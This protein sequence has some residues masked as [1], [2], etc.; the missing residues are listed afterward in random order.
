MAEGLRTFERIVPGF[1]A[2]FVTE[3]AVPFDVGSGAALRLAGGWL[4]REPTGIVVYG[5]SRGLLEHVLRQRAAGEPRLRVRSGLRARGLSTNAAGDR[6][7]GVRVTEGDA[8][9]EEPADLTVV[10]AGRRSELP[11]WL[12]AL[13]LPPAEETR[14]RSH[15]WYVSRWFEIPAG[16]DSG[17]SLMSIN[18]APGVPR[19]GA[20]LEAE[21]GRWGVVLVLPRS[22]PVPTTDRDFLGVCASLADDRLHR[23]LV[24]ARP[25]TPILRHPHAGSRWRHLERIAGWPDGLVALGDAVCLLDP[26]FG[27]GM[28]ACARG[29]EALADVQWHEPGAAARYQRTLAE[30]VRAPWRLAIGDRPTDAATIEHRRR[31]L[32]AAPHDPALARML[33]R[34]MHVLDPPEAIDEPAVV[35]AVRAA[36][37]PVERLGRPASRARAGPSPA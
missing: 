26:F 37:E 1:G 16:F 17:W 33:L 35:A 21:G 5:G 9:V 6:V 20:V 7:T 36:V 22:E 25:L 15:H 19:G 34:R 32:R 10:A 11:G 31:L 4:P 23:A 24:G 27:L 2:A 29:A 14:V 30:L 8:L 13:G 12:A 28:T 18:P 3:G